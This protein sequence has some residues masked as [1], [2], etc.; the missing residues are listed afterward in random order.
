MVLTGW[1]SEQLAR[2]PAPVVRRLMHRVF[3]RSAWDPNEVAAIRAPIDQH[4]S[5]ADRIA[6]MDARESLARVEAELFPADD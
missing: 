3:V 1:D 4:A 2:Q 5:F 6:K